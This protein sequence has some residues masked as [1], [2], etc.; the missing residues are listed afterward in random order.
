MTLRVEQS[1]PKASVAA[2]I[3]RAAQKPVSIFAPKSGVAA[4]VASASTSSSSS[5]SSSSSGTYA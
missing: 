4:A 2:S 5:S 1:A 3:A